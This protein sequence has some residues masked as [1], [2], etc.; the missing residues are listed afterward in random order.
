MS[1]V[2]VEVNCFMTAL[3]RKI[4]LPA[5]AVSHQVIAVYLR[6]RDLRLSSVTEFKVLL[7]PGC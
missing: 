7:R 6:N 2:T 4:L 1:T 5:A 3:A